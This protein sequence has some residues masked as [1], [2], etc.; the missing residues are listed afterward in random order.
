M[1]PSLVP[2]AYLYAHND[3]VLDRL[4]GDFAPADWRVRDPA[5]HD[6]LWIVGHLAITRRRLVAMA[7]LPPLGAEWDAAFQRGTRPEAVPEGID[8]TLLVAAIHEAQRQLA[9]RWDAIADTDLAKPLGRTLPDG[10]DTIGGAI[11]FL[12]WHEAYHL[13]QLG[14][15]RRLAG[16]PGLA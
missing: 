10:S 15:L 2:V 4:V 12:S 9:G 13:G 16:K 1:L 14:L 7:G 11:R 5:G 8:P 3:R 6:A